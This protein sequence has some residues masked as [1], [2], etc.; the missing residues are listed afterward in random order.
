MLFQLQVN[1]SWDC[2]DS[3]YMQMVHLNPL[4]KNK[5]ATLQTAINL[6]TGV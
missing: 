1:V 3:I 4:I 5:T 2:R 6:N